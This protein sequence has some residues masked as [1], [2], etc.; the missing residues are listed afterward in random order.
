MNRYHQHATACRFVQ[1]LLACLLVFYA[2][3]VHAQFA[4]LP[5]AQTTYPSAS[6]DKWALKPLAVFD[7]IRACSANL[8]A[9]EAEQ[10]RCQ[11]LVLLCRGSKFTTMGS[12]ANAPVQ[13]NSLW[14]V[15]V[16][17]G[18]TDITLQFTEQR[19]G[20][21][22]D[23]KLLG[24]KRIAG[25]YMALQNWSTTLHAGASRFYVGILIDELNKFPF[26]GVWKAG[27]KMHLYDMKDRGLYEWNADITLNIT[28]SHNMQIY[29]PQL[30]GN[31]PTVDLN[32]QHRSGIGA[33]AQV[34]GS[35]HIDA[36]L[37]DGFNSNSKR[38]TLTASNPEGSDFV[39]K[40]QR[41][42]PKAPNRNKISYQVLAS[43]PGSNSAGT[44][45]MQPGVP[46]EFTIPTDV[47][48]T[49]VQLPNIVGSVLCV[50]WGIELKTEMFKQSDKLA[51]NYNG[52]L[53]IIFSPSTNQLP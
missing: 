47:N 38:F 20:V 44:L 45:P 41:S 34:S 3:Q 43:T 33:S 27:L 16:N 35:A 9:T 48:V 18:G 15:P 40:N 6:F 49:A 1:V 17:N 53:N 31:T 21:T 42:D 29:L 36:C 14:G 11:N 30:T 37:Y 52:K 2:T 10:L 24:Y 19:S 25:A 4:V 46:K 51:G 23:I 13:N 50:P 32:L 8:N 39:V 5:S 12:C 22:R 28:D 26:G 7:E